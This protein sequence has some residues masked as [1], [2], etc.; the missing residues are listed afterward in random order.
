VKYTILA[1]RTRLFGYWNQ[2]CLL[3]VWNADAPLLIGLNFFALFCTI[4]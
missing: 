3:S 2:L 1:K 4:A